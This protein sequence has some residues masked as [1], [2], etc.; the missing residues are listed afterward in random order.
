MR[1]DA[2]RCGGSDS[3]E[4]EQNLDGRLPSWH[5]RRLQRNGPEQTTH[6]DDDFS[7]RL[8][9]LPGRRG[10]ADRRVRWGAAVQR[11]PEPDALCVL[12][13]ELFVEWNRHVELFELCD[14]DGRGVWKQ[15]HDKG[16]NGEERSFIHLELESEPC[17]DEIRR[18]FSVP[19][20]AG[21]VC[22]V[23]GCVCGNSWLV[24][25]D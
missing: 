22:A 12:H 9:V 7:E 5:S 18:A 23:S 6:D 10:P 19:W 20:S 17:R 14:R 13:H 25:Y 8:H 16:V 21:G 4:N 2:M 24:I 11:H 15:H 3:D 1:C